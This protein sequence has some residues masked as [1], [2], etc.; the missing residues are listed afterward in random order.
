LNYTRLHF[1]RSFSTE[2]IRRRI[3]TLFSPL[4]QNY[5]HASSSISQ[6]LELFIYDVIAENHSPYDVYTKISRITK[7]LKWLESTGKDIRSCTGFDI[8]RFLVAEVDPSNRHRIAADIKRFVRFLKEKI[9]EKYE[10][11]Y[12]SFK[13]K[14]PKEYPLP[15][16][17]SDEL[18]E[19]ILKNSS[20]FYKALFSI[21]YEGGLRLGEAL[22]IRIRHV[23]DH[24]NYIKVIV[25]KSKTMQR[26]VY[27]VTYQRYLRDWLAEHPWGSDPDAFLFPARSRGPYHQVNRTTI[28]NYILKLKRKLG[29]NTRFYPHL[30]RHKRA[31]E[32]YGKLAEKEMM[33][34]FGWKTRTM[35]D[36][37]AH[38]TQKHVEEKVLSLYGISNG[39]KQLGDIIC[40]RCGARNPREANY[41]WRCGMPLKSEALLTVERDK[42]R[43]GRLLVSL[44]KE[45]GIETPEELLNPW[46]TIH[47]S[48]TEDPKTSISKYQTI[49][50][51]Q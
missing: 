36:I 16:L 20:T 25:P 32:L 37:Y 18:I 26:A 24:G 48:N 4:Q 30:L 43:L 13:V 8:T 50:A 2:R 51:E 23:E 39:D 41:C 14:K 7:F 29:I 27:I 1:P 38:I 21:I 34:L 10:E 6:L 9:D 28:Y 22:S 15:P 40:P 3:H 17:P 49:T 5:L 31:T 33:E 45:L 11:L 19:L 12:K 35:L 44:F 46:I 47:H 42:E